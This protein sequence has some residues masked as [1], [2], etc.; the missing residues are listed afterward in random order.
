MSDQF[1]LQKRLWENRSAYAGQ[2][3]YISRRIGDVVARLIDES[4]R[5]PVI[6]LMSDHGPNLRSGLSEAEQREIRFANLTAMYLPGAPDAFLPP[7]A[8]PVNHLRRVFNLYFDAKLPLLP[9]R[10]FVS[11]YQ[12]P[13]AL[14]EV[15]LDNGRLHE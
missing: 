8:T 11:D 1:E 13:F 3:A 5:S 14:T 6:I 4:E 15:G 7:D 2:L 12:A 10:Y 9:D